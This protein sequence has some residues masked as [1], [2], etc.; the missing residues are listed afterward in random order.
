MQSALL[1]F[2]RGEMAAWEL[3]KKSTVCSNE[4]SDSSSEA[5]L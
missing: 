5:A 1:I 3:T 2:F 4:E